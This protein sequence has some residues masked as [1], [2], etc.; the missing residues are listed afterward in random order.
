VLRRIR[1]ST[2][3]ALLLSPVGVILLAAT[4][5][6]I[7][8]D[9]NTNTALAILRSAGYVNTLLGSIIPLVPILMPWVALLLLWLNQLIASLLAFAAAL[10]IS[11]AALTWNAFLS[12]AQH[13]LQAAHGGA[14]DVVAFVLAAIAAFLFLFELIGFGIRVTALSVGLVATVAIVPIMF[15]LYPLPASDVFYTS[16]LTQPWLPAET[17]TLTTHQSMTGYILETDQDWTEVLLAEDRTVVQYH[18]SQ[19]SSRAMCQIDVVASERP[20]FPL[21]NTQSELPECVL[22]TP[23]QGSGGALRP[24]QVTET[25]PCQMAGRRCE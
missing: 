19:V 23:A 8:S 22:P 9:Y 2:T 18:T 17:I 24:R 25:A 5:L 20:L 12:L 10:L 6:M 4:R 21:L 13:D 11:P 3:I 7:V 15:L 1:S 14:W 16:L